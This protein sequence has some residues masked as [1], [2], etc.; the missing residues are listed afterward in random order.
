MTFT[1]T[2]IRKLRELNLDQATFDAVLEIFEEAKESKSRKKGGVA[3]RRERGTRLE[4]D[5]QLPTEWRDRAAAMGLHHLEINREAVKFKNYW[6]NARG[7]KGIKLRWDLTWDNWCL[8]ALERLGR[9]P[10]AVGAG[11]PE[12]AGGPESFTSATWA[13]IGRRYKSSGQW[14]PEWGP[15]PGRM[16]CQM[17][18]EYL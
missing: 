10:K 7:D 6:L 1:G 12:P 9:A 15:P 2:T 18:V 17:P 8:G 13:A 14:S 3:D 4:P 5:W 16:D 11:A